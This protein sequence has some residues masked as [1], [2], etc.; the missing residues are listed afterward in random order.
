MNNLTRFQ[1]HFHDEYQASILI[2]SD[3]ERKD[4]NFCELL[5]FCCLG[6]HQMHN[7]RSNRPSMALAEILS[8][9]DDPIYWQNYM[10]LF[11][12]ISKVMTME[13]VFYYI[14]F[15]AALG[16]NI[17]WLIPIIFPL[18]SYGNINKL[19]NEQVVRQILPKVAQVKEYYGVDG[20][21]QFIARME[22]R[23]KNKFI[24]LLKTK[25][26]GILGKGV[27]YYAPMSVILAFKYL[28]TLHDDQEPENIHF[29]NM[30]LEVAHLIGNAFLQG[31]VTI[32]S[33]VSLPLEIVN[34]V[35]S[36]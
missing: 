11:S 9:I 14:P 27:N 23:N 34:H 17:N 21:K 31:K 4:K 22:L 20:Q 32:L 2:K 18:A 29:R 13:D 19:D 1:I 6:L 8:L 30:L 25:G 5:L 10:P 7:L 26:F 35:Y 36:K 15:I 28:Y 16:T 3:A 33:L 24:F 12:N